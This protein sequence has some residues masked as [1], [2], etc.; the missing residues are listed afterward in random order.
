MERILRTRLV[1]TLV[2][3]VVFSAGLLVGVAADRSVAA[4]PAV[5]QTPEDSNAAPARRVPMYEQVGPDEAQ[6]ILID[7]IVGEYRSSMKSLH[8][9]FRATYNPRYQALVDSTRTS[10]KGVLTSEQAQA[11]DSLVADLERR[12]AERGSRED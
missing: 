2:L 6:K 3:A 8:A 4:S 5:A 10:I 1:T 12:R 11:Y 7:S 9:E